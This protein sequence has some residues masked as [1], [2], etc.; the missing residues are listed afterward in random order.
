MAHFLFPKE[1][2]V[3]IS[4]P[5][6]YPFTER[7]F[8]GMQKIIWEVQYL[9]PLPVAKY[10]KKCGQKTNYA[11][12]GQ[13]R[14][15]AQGKA[16]DIWLIYKCSQCQGTWNVTFFSR[17]SPKALAPG[18]LEKFHHNDRQLARQ[19][20]MNAEILQRNSGETGLP[21]YVV[22]GEDIPFNQEIELQIKT[23]YPSPLKLSAVI[24]KKMQISRKDY[25][26]MLSSGQIKVSST[27][28]AMK[29]PGQILRKGRLLGGIVLTMNLPDRLAGG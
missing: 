9:S 27:Q 26:T 23:E 15:N 11:S 21:D 24:R 8:A 6:C 7:S 28:E 14:V 12:S 5:I 16:L 10:C 4:A 18:L 1:D 17:I 29:V 19:Y 2:E 3:L 25:E 22:A 13:F 20:A